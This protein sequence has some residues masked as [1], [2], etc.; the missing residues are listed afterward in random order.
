MKRIRIV[1]LLLLAYPSQVLAASALPCQMTG[2]AGDAV[3]SEAVE[4]V[5]MAAM[6]H[7]GHHMSAESDAGLAGAVGG[8]CDSGLCSM[9]HCQSAPALPL[10][11][12]GSTL[13]V[14]SIHTAAV[15]AGAPL[16]PI[17]SL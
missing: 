6:G 2:P 13:P 5:A 12:S 9:S 7:A 16:H 4:G 3:R 14:F 1:L 10:D 8:C 17:D 11:H 15:E